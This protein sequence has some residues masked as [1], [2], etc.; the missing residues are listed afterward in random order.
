M[1]HP[2]AAAQTEEFL[3]GQFPAPGGAATWEQAHRQ[4]ESASRS[5]KPTGFRL[6]P[7]TRAEFL[8]T[9]FEVFRSGEETGL[10]SD[11]VL[12]EN[13]ALFLIP[14]PPP[15]ER[16]FDSEHV[17]GAVQAAVADAK[18]REAAKLA[19]AGE[20]KKSDQG[21]ISAAGSVQKRFGFDIKLRIPVGRLSGARKVEASVFVE[22]FADSLGRFDASTLN[23]RDH[24][25]ALEMNTLGEGALRS[26]YL[27][28]RTAPPPQFEGTLRLVNEDAMRRADEDEK[29]PLTG[30]NSRAVRVR[31][32]GDRLLLWDEAASGWSPP[33]RMKGEP[34]TRDNWTGEGPPDAGRAG[35]NWRWVMRLPD[36]ETLD[37]DLR[38]IPAGIEKNHVFVRGDQKGVD[39]GVTTGADWQNPFR[40]AARS[41]GRRVSASGR[42]KWRQEKTKN[43]GHAPAPIPPQAH[44]VT[45]GQC[46]EFYLEAPTRAEVK[47]EVL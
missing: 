18:G 23:A 8:A 30:H 34:Q 11:A 14:R 25:D 5:K 6:R 27:F 41:E 4:R 33:L 3:S 13:D 2:I 38:E 42:D 36:L 19:A 37:D 39:G 43:S 31:I 12:A 40:D 9:H 1:S 24:L 46:V 15:H 28:F 26:I 44:A 10:N 29:I 17:R 45:S 35:E 47:G 16:L 32:E 20:E 21:G 7:P 22:F